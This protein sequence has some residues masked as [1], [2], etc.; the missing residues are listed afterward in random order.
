LKIQYA[1][2]RIPH[3]FIIALLSVFFSA[4]ILASP[5]SSQNLTVVVYGDSRSG[6]AVHRKLIEQA[7]RFQPNAVFHTGDLVT[8]PFRA[9]EWATVNEVLS[10]WPKDTPLYPALGNHEAG[11]AHY[12]KQFPQLNNQSWYTVSLPPTVW[13]VLDTNAPL[14]KGTPQYQW[15]VHTLQHATADTKIA[16]FHHPLFS[17]GMH[18]E[19]GKQLEPVLVSLFEKYKVSLVFNGHDHDYERLMRHGVQYVITGGGGAGLYHRK[20]IHPESK[21]FY[22]ANH[23]CVVNI[24]EKKMQLDVYNLAGRRIDQV[25]IPR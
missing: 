23:F 24:Q 7:K 6:H 1:N 13:I 8:H 18:G 22:K 16:V 19:D 10:T 5:P 12:F 14:A 4:S 21:A 25:V 17:S 9:D 11:S 20:R 15:L 3:F 2:S